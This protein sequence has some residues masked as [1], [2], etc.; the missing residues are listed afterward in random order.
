[1]R[2]SD[3][4]KGIINPL[5]LQNSSWF[6]K[7][8]CEH[9]PLL[10]LLP[11]LLLTVSSDSIFPSTKQGKNQ[12]ST[13]APKNCSSSLKWCLFPSDWNNF[14][15]IHYLDFIRTSGKVIFSS[16]CARIPQSGCHFAQYR[17]IASQTLQ[18]GK[19]NTFFWCKQ[20]NLSS[21]AFF[22]AVLLINNKYWLIL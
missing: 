9:F 10:L 1:M 4:E 20:D 11:L 12:G 17:W 8:E 7:Y 5:P 14:I 22:S 18:L 6:W 16:I 3:G 15:L 19:F 13:H 2:K 21:R